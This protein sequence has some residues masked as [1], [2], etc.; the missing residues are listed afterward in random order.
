MA[1]VT[2]LEETIASKGHTRA[3]AVGVIL[4]AATAGWTPAHAQVG[5]VPTIGNTTIVVRTVTGELNQ[6]RRELVLRDDI[7]H[8]EL[9]ETGENSATEL[10]FLDE[11]KLSL[12]PDSSVILDRF[13]FDPDPDRSTF[14]MSVVRG[15]LR[16]VSGRLPKE[17][18]TIHTPVATIGIR[19]TVFDIH[20]AADGATRVVVKDGAVLAA[21]C[22]RRIVLDRPGA[23]ATIGRTD[24][25]ACTAH[26]SPAAVL[27]RAA[28][29]R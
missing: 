21:A 11:T 4:L 7:Y 23:V 14:V 16:F 29:V 20:V 3:V 26:H 12:G 19:G 28:A 22:G 8:N 18:Y 6:E 17:N 27:D 2:A 5:E 25:G 15:V 1:G 13:V 24:D 10:T 9:V